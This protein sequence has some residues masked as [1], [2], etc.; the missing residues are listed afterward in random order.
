MR[1]RKLNSEKGTSMFVG[2]IA[3]VFIIPMVGLSVDVGFLYVCKTRL[4]ASVDGSALAAARAL[5]L[6]QT[7]TAQAASA[8]QNA[9]NWFYANFP[10]G[11]WA[12]LN[13]VMSSSTVQVFDDA[14]N[15]NLRNVTVTATTTVPTYFMRWLR[16]NSTTISA[17]GNASRRDV[18][19]MMVLDRS[20]SMNN[21]GACPTLKSAAKL[22]TGQFAAGRDRIGMVSFSDGTYVH[23]APTTD[24]QTR[25]GYSNNSGTGNGEIDNIVCTGYTGTAQAISIGYNELY[26]V[27]QPG[28]LNVLLLETDGLPN[29]LTLNWWRSSTA[30]LTNLGSSTGCK[31]TNGNTKGGGGWTSSSVRRN[32]TS[33]YNMGTGAFMSNIPAGM[34][35]ALASDDPG[36]NT[37]FYALANPWHPDSNQ[38]IGAAGGDSRITSSSAISNCGFLSDKNN[39]DDFAW[40][41]QTDV[42][43]NQLNPTG[44][45]M[46]VTMSSGRVAFTGDA[47]TK[48]TNYHNAALNATDNAAYRARSNSTLG[49][50]MFVIGLGGNSTY[51]PDYTLMRRIA[52]DP[53]PD[54]FNTPALYG[55][56]AST[57]SCVTYSNQPQ[58]T[59]IWSSDQTVLSSAFM[60]LSS[61]ILRLSR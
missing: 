3:L 26:K 51:T 17:V 48:W 55:T 44:A 25:L 56:C 38:G 27:N 33:G 57:P 14:A 23:S 24:F 58:G 42:Y 31:D 16:F 47:T 29:T 12:T 34:I 39:V 22:F 59:F 49:A 36:P 6:G 30:G 50:Y 2:I 32:W 20:G 41:P 15:P 35:G 10:S 13:T 19:V 1:T 5:S 8:K 40:I 45:Y 11:N 4:Q 37:D 18:V 61:Q 52:N 54:R 43:G 7:T 46:P 53:D 60:E 9:V 21:S 28:A